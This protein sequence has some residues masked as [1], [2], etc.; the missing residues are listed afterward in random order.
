[1][2]L[3]DFVEL[4]GYKGFFHWMH[5]EEYIDKTYKRSDDKD[6]SSLSLLEINVFHVFSPALFNDV[7]AS[8]PW[9]T[10]DCLSGVCY[11][12]RILWYYYCRKEMTRPLQ[13]NHRN[14]KS[15]ER[16]PFTGANVH[17]SQTK[18]SPLHDISEL[19]SLQATL[20][21]CKPDYF[22]HDYNA[23]VH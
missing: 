9:Q 12:R 3:M 2:D 6:C 16:V 22:M 10:D 17:R 8:V 14:T 20:S 19:G 15:F 13:M 5:T 7:K 18:S 1:M 4:Q 23:A 21:R 11:F